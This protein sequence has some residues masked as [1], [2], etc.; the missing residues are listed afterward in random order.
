MI[1]ASAAPS[2]IS[3][4]SI[5]QSVETP[6]PI[7]A[8]TSRCPF[9]SITRQFLMRSPIRIQTHYSKIIADVNRKPLDAVF[10]LCNYLSMHNPPRPDRRIR[11]GCGDCV[12]GEVEE[13]MAAIP[14]A[15]LCGA[16][17]AFFCDHV[18]FPL[19]QRAFD[20]NWKQWPWSSVQRD[21]EEG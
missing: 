16:G 12:W 10:H 11:V 14:V 7:S 15:V 5:R 3:P 9:F 2:I 17:A 20:W 19:L 4:F 1:F 18:M 13:M 8:A 6:M 21:A